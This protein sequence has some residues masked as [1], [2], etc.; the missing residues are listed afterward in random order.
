M[1]K[2]RICSIETRKP[3]LGLGRFLDLRMTQ[4][5]FFYKDSNTLKYHIRKDPAYQHT[6]LHCSPSILGIKHTSCTY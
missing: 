1:G 2:A 5:P 4:S 6:H 3:R